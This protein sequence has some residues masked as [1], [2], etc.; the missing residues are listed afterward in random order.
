MSVTEYSGEPTETYWEEYLSD[1]RALS[2]DNGGVKLTP[3]YKDYLV[4][5]SDKDIQIGE[6]E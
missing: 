6:A 3:S 2:M 5:L 4:W 1:L